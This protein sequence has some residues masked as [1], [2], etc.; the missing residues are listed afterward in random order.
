MWIFLEYRV[1]ETLED[2]LSHLQALGQGLHSNHQ[3][4]V[5]IFLK[6]FKEQSL[7]TCWD[8]QVSQHSYSQEA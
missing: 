5:D 7:E 3:K 6:V 2:P 4:V 1:K 8:V